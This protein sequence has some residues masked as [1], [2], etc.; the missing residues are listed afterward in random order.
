[1]DDD[2]DDAEGRRLTFDAGANGD[3]VPSILRTLR[4][5]GTPATFFLTGRFVETFPTYSGQIA[6]AHP[7][8]NHSYDH[9]EFTGLTDA[10][11][12]TQLADDRAAD[13][14]RDR[15]HHQAVVP[16]PVRRP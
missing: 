10:A 12:R 4:E 2:P 13:Q 9:P 11:I 16:L 14:R 7:V 15:P 6:A 8:G 5:T 3:A 1:V